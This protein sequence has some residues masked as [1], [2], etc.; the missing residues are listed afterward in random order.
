MHCQK[1]A[2]TRIDVNKSIGDFV[3]I[4]DQSSPLNAFVSI[5]YIFANGKN[6][7][8]RD[9]TCRSTKGRLSD[10]EPDIEVDEIHRNKF[11]N[12]SVDRVMIYKN[13][14]AGVINKESPDFYGLWFFSN[15][16]GKWMSAGEDIGGET[17]LEAEITFREK[18]ERNLQSYRD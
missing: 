1:T 7:Q 15:E 18:A 10:T 4:N 6:S 3:E 12:T 17:V 9:M 5:K 13:S 8:Y 14:V 2:Y 11:L 16:N